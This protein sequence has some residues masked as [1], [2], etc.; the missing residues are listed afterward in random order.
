MAGGDD[1]HNI[2][3]PHFIFYTCNYESRTAL[4]SVQ[5]YIHIVFLKVSLN[6]IVQKIFEDKK[7]KFLKQK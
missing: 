2:V 4:K 3:W 6:V 5:T 7:S 1:M